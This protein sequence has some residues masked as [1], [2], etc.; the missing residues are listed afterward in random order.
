MAYPNP[1]SHNFQGKTVANS[2][3][4]DE[5]FDPETITKLEIFETYLEEWLPVFIQSRPRHGI[6]VYDFLQDPAQIR[7]ERPVL[8]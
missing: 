2:K 4:H 1:Q 7:K 6:H 5:P 8:R 3:F